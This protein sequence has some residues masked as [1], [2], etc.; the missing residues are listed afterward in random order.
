MTTSILEA[1]KR[2]TKTL[3]LK[4]LGVSTTS[5]FQALRYVWLIKTDTYYKRSYQFFEEELHLI[6]WFLDKN[7]VAIDIGALGANW[8]YAMYQK[9]GDGGA[10]FA[11]EAHPFHAKSTQ[12][13]IS[14]LRMKS[15]KFFPIGLSDKTEEVFLKVAQTGGERLEGRSYIEREA[16][17]PSAGYEKVHLEQLDS[18]ISTNPRMLEA[19]LIKCDVEGYE[20]FVLQ[21]AKN[22]LK[23]ARPYVVLEKGDYNRLGYSSSDI[24]Q[25]FDDLHYYAFATDGMESISMTNDR[26]EHPA[27]IGANRIFIPEERLENFQHIINPNDHLNLPHFGHHH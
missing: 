2:S 10:V 20:L 5:K 7:E 14:F 4:F 1:I 16:S 22:L 21:G 26:L 11:F 8:T 19:K 25:F 18:L 23:A 9:V 17:G 12:A 13:A 3:L 27:A 24:Y 15:V 6:P